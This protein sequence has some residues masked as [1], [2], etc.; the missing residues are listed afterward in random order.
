MRLAGA[1]TLVTGATGGLGAAIARE[2]AGAGARVVVSGRRAEALEPLMAELDARAVVA[3]LADRDAP[4]R[5]AEEA[6]PVDV[7]VANH[8]LPASGPLDEYEPD[9][10][11]RAL[12]VNLRAPVLL[13]RLLLPGMLERGS[14]HLVFVSSLNAKA[15]TH[16]TALYST[17]KAGMR[18][19][20]LALAQ[21]LHGRGVGVTT[22]FPGF[23]RD[24]GMFAK[25]G[26]QLPRGV[27]TRTPEDVG[28]AVLSGIE[29]NR[30]EVA[31]APVPLRVL[32]ALAGLAPAAS[33][34]IA[35]RLGAEKVAADVTAA[36]RDLR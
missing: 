31:V 18:A 36:Q 33:A 22:V 32:S 9:Q 13:A 21:D 19:L 5:L 12:D 24:A 15:P 16:G 29:R 28:R 26:A 4:A 10:I 34:T 1:T 14:G 8:A 7:L 11:D 27:G 25:T 20:A 35:R 23:I 6:G 30:L 17:T 3:D 2:L